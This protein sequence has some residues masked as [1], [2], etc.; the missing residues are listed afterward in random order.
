MDDTETE[1]LDELVD[2]PPLEFSFPIEAG[3]IEEFAD[4]IHSDHDVFRDPEAAAAEGYDA[5]PAPITFVETYRFERSRLGEYEPDAYFDNQLA[6]HG[7]QE[8]D[9]HRQPVAGDRLTARRSLEETFTKE[10]SAG[11]LI[12]GIFKTEYA[13]ADGEPVVTTRK[14]RIITE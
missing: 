6:L 4:A 13:D 9:I 14:T 5:I 8:Y 10:G 3:K 1:R 12:F 7:A 11:R 2:V